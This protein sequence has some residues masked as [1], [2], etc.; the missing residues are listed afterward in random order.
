MY[1]EC[2]CRTY[3]SDHPNLFV[4]LV[5][6]CPMHETASDLLEE[7]KQIVIGWKNIERG[8]VRGRLRLTPWEEERLKFAQQAIAQAEG[9]D[10]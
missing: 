1:R 10:A 5:E 8:M 4:P 6:F 9:G 3:M 7:L 2:G